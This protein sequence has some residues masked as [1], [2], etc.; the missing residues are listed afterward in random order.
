MRK[1]TLISNFYFQSPPTFD[2]S[3]HSHFPII[4]LNWDHVMSGGSR[5]QRHYLIVLLLAMDTNAK[6]DVLKG[7]SKS[8]VVFISVLSV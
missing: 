2:F 7:F 3:H 6:N 5:R 4:Q 8:A 1:L